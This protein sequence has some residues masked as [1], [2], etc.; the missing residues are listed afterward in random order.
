M[1][2]KKYKSILK[3]INEDSPL[4][5]KIVHKI[6][7][8]NTI[9]KISDVIEKII[10]PKLLFLALCATLITYY[11]LLYI[12]ILNGFTIDFSTLLPL[13]IAYIIVFYTLNFIKNKIR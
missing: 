5:D 8:K 1:Q 4:R 10:I 2:D 11:I 12:C 7:H 6:I 13:F 3:F 9:E